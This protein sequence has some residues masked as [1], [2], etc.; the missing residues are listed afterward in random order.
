MPTQAFISWKDY[1]AESSD[2]SFAVQDVGAANYASVTQDIQEV[3]TAMQAVSLATA[4]EDGFRKTFPQSF[5][6]PDDP[7]AQR[8]RRWSV[9]M[10]DTTPFLAALSTVANPGYGKT[11]TFTIPGA[12]IEADSLL[13]HT[14]IADVVNNTAM[15]AL[16]ASLNANIRSPWNHTAVAPATEVVEI[17]LVGRNN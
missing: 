5:D 3:R 7:N 17:L 6:L 2:T 4:Q 9:K 8:E 12:K 14:D 16:V 11:F 10:R 13:E 1:D 15:A